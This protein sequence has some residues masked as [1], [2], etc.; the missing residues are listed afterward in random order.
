MFNPKAKQRLKANNN[1]NINHKHAGSADRLE[2]K[3]KQMAKIANTLQKEKCIQTRTHTDA[4]IVYALGKGH[5][6]YG[7]SRICPYTKQECVARESK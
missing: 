6:S 3:V 7:A 5:P 1:N 2:K 4:H